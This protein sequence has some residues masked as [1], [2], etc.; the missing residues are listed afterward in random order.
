[1]S[2]KG[3]RN[4][5]Y[6]DVTMFGNSVMTRGGVACYGGLGSGGATDQSQA[7]VQ[8]PAS[9][10]G[11][12]P[13]GLLLNDMVS[14]D[15]TR[16]HINFYQ[17]QVVI[18]GKVTLGKKGYWVTNSTVQGPS[19]ITIGDLAVLTSSGN[20]MNLPAAFAYN[21]ASAWNRALNPQVGKFISTADEDGYAKVQVEVL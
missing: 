14:I 8:Y 12:V 4:E 16:Q 7:F 11:Q 13:A 2:L 10:S 3:D 6:V 9:S 17:D 15:L 19:P 20:I 21:T 5:L 18:G 1:M